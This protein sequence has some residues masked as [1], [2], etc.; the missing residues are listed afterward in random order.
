MAA[1]PRCV[2]VPLPVALTVALSGAK[3]AFYLKACVYRWVTTRTQRILTFL[4]SSTGA[5][6]P[7]SIRA[8]PFASAK[9]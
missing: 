8:E 9:K 6:V 3:G 4:R 5:A 2:S 1:K 7:V